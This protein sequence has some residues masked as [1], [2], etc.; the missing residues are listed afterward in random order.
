MDILD[1]VKNQVA[2]EQFVSFLLSA[3]SQ[4]YFASETVEY[5]LVA[6]IETDERLTPLA[7]INTRAI[8]L[9]NLADLQGRRTFYRKWGTEIE[10]APVL[11]VRVT[12]RWV[13]RYLR[14]KKTR[15]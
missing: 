4:Q 6:G 2:A 15:S 8:D 5:P 3:I 11:T 1:T 14:A 12:G 10:P 9:S 13:G 7:E